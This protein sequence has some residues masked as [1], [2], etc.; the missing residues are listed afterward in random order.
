MQDTPDLSKIVNLIMQNPSLIAEISSL[1]KQD[2]AAETPTESE[3]NE[4]A[5]APSELKS[6]PIQA[7]ASH[8]QRYELLSALKP[9]LSESRRSAIDYMISVSEIFNMIRKK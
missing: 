2:A 4:A 9:Y 6:A 3:A 5:N 8:S 1:V 7:D